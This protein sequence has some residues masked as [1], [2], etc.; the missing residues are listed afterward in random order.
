[1]I[2]SSLLATCALG[3]LLAAPLAGCHKPEPMKVKI[4]GLDTGS[5]ARSVRVAKVETR[6][7]SGGLSASGLLVSREEAA[8]GSELVGYRIAKVFVEEGAMVKTGQ[9]LVKLDDTL[10][11]AQIEQ[12]RAL[13]R[14]QT[15]AARLA[16][17]EASRVAGLDGRGILSD[18]QIQQRRFQAEN[19]KAALA[20]QTAQLREFL[21]RQA[22]MT[23]RAPVA[24]RVLERTVRPGDVSGG[25]TYFRIARDGLVELDAEAPELDLAKIK[26]G[27]PAEVTLSSGK[28]LAGKVRLISP[29]IDVQSRLGRVR[30]RLPAILTLCGR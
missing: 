16:A 15:L 12:Q 7:L 9:P 25:G 23:V 24:G 19:A 17:D 4:D 13:L 11:Q 18:E 20:A 30:V 21:T 2:R 28:I 22:R 1:M 27:D 6:G 14:Q 8:A 26:V 10:L 29:K 3:V 5:I